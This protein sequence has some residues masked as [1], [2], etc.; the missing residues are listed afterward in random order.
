VIIFETLTHGTVRQQLLEL[1]TASLPFTPIALPEDIVVH[2]ALEAAR[3]YSEG[4][5]IYFDYLPQISTIVLGQETAQNYDLIEANETLPAGR[6]Y[7]SPKPAKLAISSGSSEFLVHLRKGLEEW[8]R[9]A[10]VEPGTTTTSEVP[11]SLN[12]EQAPLTG[13]ARLFIYIRRQMAA[14]GLSRPYRAGGN[15]SVNDRLCLKRPFRLAFS[16]YRAGLRLWVSP[17][18]RTMQ[19]RNQYRAWS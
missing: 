4:E 3:R 10:K 9:E 19:W 14:M 8:P 16:L 18:A 7:R 17:S 12:V 6:V 15:G 13:R 11:V 1:L 2:G 5:P